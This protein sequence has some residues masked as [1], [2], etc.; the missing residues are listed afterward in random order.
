M[1]QLSDGAILLGFR[2][3]PIILASLSPRRRDLLRMLGVRYETIVPDV[4]EGNRARGESPSDYVARLARAKACWVPVGIPGHAVVAADTVVCV[5]GAVLE[6]PEDQAHAARILRLLS[7]RW[8]D[9]LTGICVRRLRDGRILVAVESTRVRFGRLDEETIERY[10]GTAE[11]MDKA[12]AYGIQ[13]FGGLLVERIEGCYFN[14]MGLPL[15]LLRR[16]VLDLEEK[17]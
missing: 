17:P 5:D 4:E 15:P 8:H 6:K 3:E 1:T 9:V 7:D 14:V 16:T 13:G 2:G 11:P 10:I 12:G